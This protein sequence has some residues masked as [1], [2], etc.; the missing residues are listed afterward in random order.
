[1]TADASRRI[2]ESPIGTIAN[3]RDLPRDLKKDYCPDKL[4]GS[5]VS[6]IVIKVKE[7]RR[8]KVFGEFAVKLIHS[9]GREFTEKETRKLFKTRA[10]G[11]ILKIKI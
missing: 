1:M 10:R 9:P 11:I 7:M 4:I 6:G 2:L 3:Q 5:G 8:R